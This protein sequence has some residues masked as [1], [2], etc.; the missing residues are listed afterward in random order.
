M[1]A[2]KH[3]LTI[4]F[5]G[6]L[7]LNAHA[8]VEQTKRLYV[9]WIV[10][11]ATKPISRST[12]KTIVDAVYEQASKHRIDPLLVLTMINIESGFR[13]KV[14]NRN[15]SGLMQ[16]IPYWHRDK[17]AGRNIFDVRTNIEVG[18]TIL[19]DCLIK[20]KDNFAKAV[21]CY[22]GGT[23][24]YAKKLRGVYAELKRMDVEMRFAKELPITRT[25][26]FGKPRLPEEIA[27][28]VI[29]IATL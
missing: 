27:A 13:P 1:N 12:A 6:I 10:D 24:N 3:I 23:K 17:I 29:K 9:Q 14:R 8:N 18:T 26:V 4:L 15:A 11:V 5:F 16:V 19:Q 25:A 7:S 20:V 28:P 2:F 21:S 22:S